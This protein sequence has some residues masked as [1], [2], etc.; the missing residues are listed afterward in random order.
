[1]N[2]CKSPAP[3]PLFS[4]RD[5]LFATWIDFLGHKE[6]GKAWQSMGLTCSRIWLHN[7]GVGGRCICEQQ[8]YQLPGSSE[9]WDPNGSKCIISGREIDL[10]CRLD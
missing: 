3:I 2:G 7:W 4:P 8:G 10:S 6:P 9:L 5:L 1:M